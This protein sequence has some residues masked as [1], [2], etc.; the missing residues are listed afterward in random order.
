[1]VI[2]AG[3]ATRSGRMA[4]ELTAAH[5]RFVRAA[6]FEVIPPTA[7]TQLLESFP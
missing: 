2:V 7:K 1:L 4:S 5:T 3:N 6:E